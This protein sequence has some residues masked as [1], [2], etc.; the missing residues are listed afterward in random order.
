[1]K[2]SYLRCL[3]NI[4]A[5]RSDQQA[6][7]P[8]RPQGVEGDQAAD[9]SLESSVYQSVEVTGDEEITQGEVS[10]RK[11]QRDKTES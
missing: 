9:R 2:G 3:L 5:C 7:D 1:M 10:D 6:L 8:Q 4:C 11:E